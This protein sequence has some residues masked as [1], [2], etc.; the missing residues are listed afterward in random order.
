MDFTERVAIFVFFGFAVWALSVKFRLKDYQ[1][2]PLSW[3]DL[4]I[5]LIGLVMVSSY[6][7]RVAPLARQLVS[8]QDSWIYPLRDFFFYSNPWTQFACHVLFADFMA[9]WMH[10]FLHTRHVWPFHA[11]HHSAKSLNVLSGMRGSPVHYLLVNLPYTFSGLLMIYAGHPGVTLT[12]FLIDVLV[13]HH[14]HSALRIPYT[15]YVEYLFITPRLHFVHHH[16]NPVYTDSNYGF[17]F[18]W[19]DKI[20]GTFTDPDQVRL[21]EKGQL[22]LDYEMSHLKLFL[23][24]KRPAI[25]SSVPPT[26]ER[27]QKSA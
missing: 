6:E 20:F 13:Q 16:P 19:W 8:M 5:T 1:P 18:S 12:L 17:V 27:E 9:Y 11:F 21:E 10:R 14:T 2:Q 15:K 22:G 23:G 4:G 24:F 25:P 26:K 7:E 3:L